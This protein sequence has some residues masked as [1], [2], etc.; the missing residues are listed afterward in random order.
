MDNFVNKK[1]IQY[2]LYLP[3]SKNAFD[4]YE[5]RLKITDVK[6]INKEI[7][8][9]LFVFALKDYQENKLTIEEFSDISGYLFNIDKVNNLSLVDVN[10]KLNMAIIAGMELFWYSQQD[11]ED[12]K[13]WYKK[14]QKTIKNYPSKKR[15]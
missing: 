1:Q 5:K 11:N 12:S 14:F 3:A 10:N 4:M 15:Q 2:K 6:E 8:G 9:K 13:N 7:I